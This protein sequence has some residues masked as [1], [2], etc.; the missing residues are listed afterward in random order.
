METPKDKEQQLKW[1]QTIQKIKEYLKSLIFK[2]TKKRI[3]D[4]SDP[5]DEELSKT[6]EQ[7]GDEDG[8]Q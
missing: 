2:K 7:L 1:E 4:I 3:K 8:T 5:T 6:L